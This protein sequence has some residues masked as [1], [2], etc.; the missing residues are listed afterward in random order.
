[1]RARQSQRERLW[2]KDIDFGYRQILVRD[3]KGQKD[4]V[5]MLPQMVVEPRRLHLEKVSGLCTNKTY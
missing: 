1:V 4:R 2:V 3:G 5:T